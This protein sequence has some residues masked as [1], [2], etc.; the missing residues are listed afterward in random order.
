M[1]RIAVIIPTY[2][3]LERLKQLLES[4]KSQS[5]PFDHFDVCISDD[6]STDGTLTF[7]QNSSLHFVCNAHRGPAATRNQGVKATQAPFLLFVDDDAVA[8]FCWLEAAQHSLPED[9]D[10]F[11]IAEGAVLRSGGEKPLT[12]SV[13][14]PGPGGYLACN[15]LVS[16]KLFNH[17][18]GFDERFKYPFN[19]D[20][21]FFLR[22]TK[23]TSVKFIERMMVFHPVYPLS[24]GA[25]LQDA[26]SYARRRIESE[27]LLY[28]IHP[29]AFSKVKATTS[30]HRSI[31]RLALFYAL[32]FGF[33][34]PGILLR[35]PLLSL[36]WFC[37]CGLRQLCFLIY[38]LFGKRI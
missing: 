8:D 4:L 29:Q 28:T 25:S 11:F 10:S 26:P 32:I 5:L 3:R 7:L 38:F 13:H 14:H 2:N 36:Q 9:N 12:H 16:R 24:F 18:S 22:A 19:E 30:A 31:L 21:D 27:Q 37:V 20:Y 6:G 17:L 23:V 15:L 35:Y 34:K 33:K 1:N